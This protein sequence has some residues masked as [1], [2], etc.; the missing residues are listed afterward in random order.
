M[1]LIRTLQVI[2]DYGFASVEKI[3]TKRLL[4]NSFRT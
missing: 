1:C 4:E 3:L 2:I